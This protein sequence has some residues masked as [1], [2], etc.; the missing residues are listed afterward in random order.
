[1]LLFAV[2]FELML[3]RGG[4]GG[5]FGFVTTVTVVGYF[6]VL[7]IV[8]SKVLILLNTL[9]MYD[10]VSSFSPLFLFLNYKNE[11]IVCPVV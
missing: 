1:M 9:H 6:H 7:C 10:L 3:V 5:I 2:E 8:L 4:G 11:K